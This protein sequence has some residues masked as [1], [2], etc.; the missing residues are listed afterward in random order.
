MPELNDMCENLNLTQTYVREIIRAELGFNQVV[1]VELINKNLKIYL[2]N[3]QSFVIP[4]EEP[5]INEYSSALMALVGNLNN[6]NIINA[7]VNSKGLLTVTLDNGLK[8]VSDFSYLNENITNITGNLEDLNTEVKTSLVASINEIKNKTKD[9]LALYD[10]NIAAGAGANGWADT[11]ISLPFGRN[12]RQKNLDIVSVKDYGAKGDGVTDDTVAIN[13]AFKSGATVILF[14]SGTYLLNGY[15]K[16]QSNTYIIGYGATVKF[17]DYTSSLHLMSVNNVTVE[18]LKIDGNQYAWTFWSGRGIG[19]FKSSYI[20]I[21]NVE[22]YNCAQAAIDIG[23]TSVD[24]LEPIN[25][26]ILVDNCYLHDLGSADIK[27][28][29]AYGNGVAVV[30]GK[31]VVIRNNWIDNVYDIGGINL[32][33]LLQENIIIEGNRLTNMTAGCPAIKLWAGGI[34]DNADYVTIKDNIISGVEGKNGEIAAIHIN[35][36]GKAVTIDNNKI[37][38][39]QSDGIFVSNAEDITIINNSI[40]NCPNASYTV[41]TANKAIVFKNNYI[42]YPDNAKDKPTWIETFGGVTSVAQIEGN[43]FENSPKAALMAVF[44][45]PSVIKGNTFINCRKD[46]D[47]RGHVITH[48]VASLSKSIIGNNTFKDNLG[49]LGNRLFAFYDFSGNHPDMVYLSDTW[50]VGVDNPS[51]YDLTANGA[52][53]ETKEA[54]RTSPP[55]EGYNLMGRTVYNADPAYIP[56]M[57]W[58][59]IRS[60]T[61]GTWVPFG[62]IGMTRQ[63]QAEIASVSSY[64]NTV[65]KYIG[66]TVLNITDNKVYYATGMEKTAK[67][68]TFDNTAS[69]TP[70]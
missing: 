3:G 4:M 41:N 48:T 20:T 26:K 16:P 65:G 34:D 17:T 40:R 45:T 64:V 47:S 1:K 56:V 12:Q 36:G 24:P 60:G 54:L 7:Y 22:I 19:I 6:N 14:N 52:Y 31:D 38:D 69:I 21:R 25:N 9:I 15:I 11:L 61:P 70:A 28:Y 30:R 2:K 33:G 50:Q 23:Q 59:C 53:I 66:R 18:G 5:F 44:R 67:W 46:T 13:N 35:S 27:T 62:Q 37:Y 29:Y 51:K 49:N 39:C 8:I 55:T 68:F 63:T 43:T 42:N 58:T 10:K 32:E 57:G